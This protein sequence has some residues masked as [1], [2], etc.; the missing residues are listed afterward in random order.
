MAATKSAPSTISAPVRAAATG[1]ARPC[2]AAGRAI[3]PARKATNATGP[4]A[5]VAAAAR[6]TAAS[7]IGQPGRTHPDAEARGGV[8]AEFEDAQRS[9][10]KRDGG[11]Q[12]QQGEAENPGP[13][14]VRG[15]ERAVQPHQDVGGSADIRAGQQEADHGM[16]G[17]GDA[18]ADQD[19]PAAGGIAPLSA[20]PERSAAGDA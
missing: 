17:R 19:Q 15:V 2:R 16:E 5:A 1:E 13:V 4:A 8:V 20:G 18:H 14:P 12:H 9:G 3:G 10:E 6:P 11:N 7:T